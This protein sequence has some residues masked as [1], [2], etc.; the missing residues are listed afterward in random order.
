LVRAGLGGQ[1]HHEPPARLYSAPA[2]L[3]TTL[4]S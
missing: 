4:N 3:V 2:L 1:Y